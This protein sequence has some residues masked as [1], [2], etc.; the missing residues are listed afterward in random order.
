MHSFKKRRDAGKMAGA[1]GHTA[2]V[3]AHPGL[4]FGACDTR[5]VNHRE[6]DV[7]LDRDPWRQLDLK[8]IVIP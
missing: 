7:S 2:I 1:A 6:K 4:K 3:V 8:R 5:G